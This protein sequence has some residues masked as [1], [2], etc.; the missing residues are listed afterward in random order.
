MFRTHPAIDDCAVI[1]ID[2]P[3]WGQ[4]VAIAVIP[5]EDAS[6][7]DLALDVLRVWGRQH[8]SAPKV[9]SRLLVVDDLPRNAM[10]KVMKT[11]VALLFQPGP[12]T[13]G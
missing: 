3:Q 4:R 12:D 6:T 10:G 7:D 2:D 11:E 13:G 9:P 1:G 8:L 5:A